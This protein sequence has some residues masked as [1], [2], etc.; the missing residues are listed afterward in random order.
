MRISAITDNR[1]SEALPPLRELR[2]ANK[3][4]VSHRFS[5]YKM[6]LALISEPEKFR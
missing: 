1:P 4:Y 3:Y 2:K 6:Q 5:L